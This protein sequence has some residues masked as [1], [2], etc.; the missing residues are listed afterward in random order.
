MR[1]IQ[2]GGILYEQDQ[3]EALHLLACLLPMRLHQRIK[4]DIGFIEQSIHGFSIFPAVR[5]GGPRGSR[6]LSH[7]SRGRHGSSCAAHVFELRLSKGPFGPLLWVQYF[8]RFHPSILPDCKMWVKDSALARGV[9]EMEYL[10]DW[11]SACSWLQRP[12][13]KCVNSWLSV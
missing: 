2:V 12:G 6:I 13:K 7:V 3:W 4:G 1:E 10:W 9:S 11:G 5:L 8:L